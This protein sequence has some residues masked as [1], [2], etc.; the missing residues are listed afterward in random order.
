M[1]FFLC[2]SKDLYS[3]IQI[4]G[5]SSW[6]NINVEMVWSNSF[7]TK[8]NKHVFLDYL[9]LFII[10]ILY[11]KILHTVRSKLQSRSRFFLDCS[12]QSH[13]LWKWRNLCLFIF[14]FTW[15]LNNHHRYSR[16]KLYTNRSVFYSTGFFFLNIAIFINKCTTR[17]N[18]QIKYSIYITIYVKVFYYSY[19]QS[20]DH[21]GLWKWLLYVRFYLYH[22]KSLLLYL[23][24]SP[25]VIQPQVIFFI[26]MYCYPC[27]T[28]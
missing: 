3:I 17:Y 26:I 19:D 2:V 28:M 15:L 24:Q 22:A 18:I 20:H 27:H 14:Q 23:I 25:F 6:P 12:D 13:D 1:C 4:I 11:R 10:G 9:G 8:F 16:V 7:Q 21:K 5:V